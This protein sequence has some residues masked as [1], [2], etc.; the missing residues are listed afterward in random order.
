MSAS[1]ETPR[2]PAAAADRLAEWECAPP[3]RC[4]SIFRALAHVSPSHLADHQL[5]DFATRA[6]HTA[7]AI[8]PA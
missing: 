2:T 8:A 6:A 5:F 1:P 3:G 7:P 4:E